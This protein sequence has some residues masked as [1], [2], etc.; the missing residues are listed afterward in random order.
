MKVY[1]TTDVRCAPNFC[2]RGHHLAY[3]EQFLVFCFFKI[4]LSWTYELKRPKRLQ[5]SCGGRCVITHRLRVQPWLQPPGA[6]SSALIRLIEYSPSNPVLPTIAHSQNER[7]PFFK[8]R[9]LPPISLGLSVPAPTLT[10]PLL[11]LTGIA[12]VRLTDP[13]QTINRLIP[14]PRIDVSYSLSDT[15]I[16][17]TA[18][19]V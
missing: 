10:K 11:T 3:R 18:D 7:D 16:S 2:V 19:V 9:A 6:H 13:P 14:L 5:R 1:Q 8:S 4:S 12:R 15:D 17:P